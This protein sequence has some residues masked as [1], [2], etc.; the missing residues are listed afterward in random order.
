M[1]IKIIIKSCQTLEFNF[2]CFDSAEERRNFNEIIILIFI[3]E[4][5]GLSVPTVL[6]QFAFCA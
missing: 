1:W 5:I 6:S 2:V 3:Y 4:A